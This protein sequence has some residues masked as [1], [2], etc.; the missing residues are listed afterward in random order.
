ML[1]HSIFVFFNCCQ[2]VNDVLQ[3]FGYFLRLYERRNKFSYQLRKKLKERNQMKIKLSACVI[4]KFNWYE[5]I[6]NYLNFKF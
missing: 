4:Q 5:L 6:R 3:D 1:D 2:L